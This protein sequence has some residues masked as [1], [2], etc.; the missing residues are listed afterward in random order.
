[1]FVA[2]FADLL[3]RSGR[4]VSALAA[5]LPCAGRLNPSYDIGSNDELRPFNRMKTNGSSIVA[6]AA[7]IQASKYGYDL[8]SSECRSTPQLYR[9]LTGAQA[10]RAHRASAR[11]RALSEQQAYARFPRVSGQCAQRIAVRRNSAQE[12]G[13]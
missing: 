4:V 12:R 6:F 2:N 9:G 3:W 5:F 10:I 13:L 11:L 8:K 7:G 1:M